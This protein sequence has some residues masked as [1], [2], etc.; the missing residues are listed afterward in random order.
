MANEKTLENRIKGIFNS[1]DLSQEQKKTMK[2]FD[3]YLIAL[4]HPIH[5][6]Q[7]YAYFMKSLALVIQ[8][9]FEQADRKDIEMFLASK[10]QFSRMTQFKHRVFVKSFYKKLFNYDNDYPEN[11]KW[12][13]RNRPDVRK[14]PQDMITEEE[15]SAMI[16]ACTNPRD[17]CLLSMLMDLGLRAGELLKINL[18]HIKFYDDYISIWVQTSKTFQGEVFAVKCIPHLTTW[19]E[20]HPLKN[21]KKAPLFIN[22]KD[23][24]RLSQQGLRQ[25]IR[26]IKKKA[27][28]HQER[29]IY[30]HLFRFTTA[31]KDSLK[32][33][34]P[35]LRK[36]FRWR[37]NSS[38]PAYYQSIS[39]EDYKN[40][41]V[42][43]NG[44]GQM[45]KC[46]VCGHVNPVTLEF[47]QNCHRPLRIDD[48][49]DK[50]DKVSKR[51]SRKMVLD[52]LR[53]LI[54]NSDDPEQLLRRMVKND[55]KMR[56]QLGELVDN[57]GGG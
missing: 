15:F 7:A 3:A 25:I 12:I 56:K 50:A 43:S 40:T 10:T 46:D 11:V 36:K 34:E 24:E 2:E 17:K 41:V 22:S 9:P 42:D 57:K 37:P 19:M 6:R 49:V 21:T 27:G 33:T 38:M 16:N 8:K 44:Q 45:I 18:E 32:Y 1:P 28:I 5:T 48:A 35:I 4:G 14:N 23:S 30:P 39:S 26:R 55:P 52:F 29:R 53:T 31:T 54:E 47:C 51:P 20:A 13:K